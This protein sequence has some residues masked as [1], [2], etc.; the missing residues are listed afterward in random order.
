MYVKN[1]NRPEVTQGLYPHP[2]HLCLV[3]EEDPPYTS[4]DQLFKQL[5]GAF[6]EEFIEAF[7]P[8]LYKQIDFKSMKPLSEEVFTGVLDGNKRVL[9]M[10]IEV[11]WK[12][13]DT[14]IVIHIE[15]QN[16][17][18]SDFNVRMFKYFSLLYNKIEKP[19]IPIAIF[20]YE[21]KWEENEFKMCF[22]DLEVLHFKYLSLHLRKQNWRKFIKQDNPV[23]AALL[24]K[25]GYTVE[26]R[27]KVKLEF[28]KIL[29]RLKLDREANNM[30][31]GFF[32]SYL[33]LSEKEEEIFVS[34]AKKLE[35]ADE[36]L[37]LPISYEERG[38]AKGREE[39]IR[40]GMK[41]VALKMFADGFSDKKIMELTDLSKEEIEDLKKQ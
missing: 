33:S 32:E 22:S 19:I 41:K 12:K 2:L 18:Q 24:S 10:V 30:L 8:K 21:D 31:L 29:S 5:I 16:Y 17:K 28:I 1:V 36:I 20:S 27:V 11:K 4:H 9:D 6:F 35:N 13:T 39:G 38:K 40:E 25:M 14:L 7:F 3:R 23:A 37:E 26:E 15:P 34:E